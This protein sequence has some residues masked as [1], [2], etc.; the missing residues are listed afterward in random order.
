MALKFNQGTIALN[1]V[2]LFA[3]IISAALVAGAQ[4]ASPDSV[5]SSPMPV[6][7]A[8]GPKPWLQTR[9]P[10]NATRLPGTDVEEINAAPATV[11]PKTPPSFWV[12]AIENTNGYNS[13]SVVL[14]DLNDDGKAD[15][16]ATNGCSDSACQ[17]DGSIAVRLGNGDGTFQSAAT[18]DSGGGATTGLAVADVN[19]DGKLDI[20]VANCSATPSS[21]CADGIVGVLLGNGNG[22][23]RPAVTY[24]TGGFGA[25]AVTV[26]DV[27]GDGK[28]DVIVANEWLGCIACATGGVGVLLGNGN[29]TFQSAVTYNSGGYGVWSVAVADVN[30]DGKPDVILTDCTLSSENFCFAGSGLVGVLLGNGNGTFQPV[31][32]YDSGG[33]IAVSVSVG[34]LNGDGKP[35]LVVSNLDSQTVGV[36]I[37]NGNGTFQPAVTYN[38]KEFAPYR[39]MI[40]DINGDGKPDLIVENMNCENGCPVGTV[41]L[42]RGN[43]DGTF[44]SPLNFPAGVFRANSVAVADLNGDGRPDMVVAGCTI[45]SEEACLTDNIGIVLNNTG[46]SK[47]TT[48]LN[49][50]QSPTL[51]GQPVTFTATVSSKNGAIPDGEPV[52]F[53]QRASSQPIATS[54]TSSGVASFSTSGFKASQYTIRATYGGDAGFLSSTATVRQVVELAQTSTTLTSNPNP[55]PPGSRV[56]FNAQVT[57]TGPVAPTGKVT[58]FQDG[59]ILLGTAPLNG[60]SA[61]LIKAAIGSITARY[62]GDKAN[63]KSTSAVL[64]QVSQA[65]SR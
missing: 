39:S 54:A 29:G 59:T 31:V 25:T 62:D 40:T 35:D 4:T 45:S 52:M 50:S 13:S 60:G 36:L 53:Y 14:A 34:D 30:G 9:K 55:S 56:T 51:V 19:H 11:S 1:S 49:T 37:G 43:G 41:S 20:V 46:A 15:L 21:D 38:T 18:Y 44:A 47:S 57:T 7:M 16:I 22:T 2:V 17:N 32:T 61:T 48:V 8:L 58:F 12:N 26:A 63:A 64:N 28:P 5:E 65:V 10:S 24:S 33:Q 42:L 27:N 6:K 23:F 3:L